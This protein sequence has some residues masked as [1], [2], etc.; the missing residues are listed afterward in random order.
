MKM[1]ILGAGFDKNFD[2]PLWDE[3]INKFSNFVA[4]N[5]NHDDSKTKAKIDSNVSKDTNNIK[6]HNLKNILRNSVKVKMKLDNEEEV[7]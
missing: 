2:L 4:L 3:F 6:L 7:K 5:T 1:L